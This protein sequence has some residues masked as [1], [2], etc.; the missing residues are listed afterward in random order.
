MNIAQKYIL[1]AYYCH[2]ST[3]FICLYEI[4]LY[5][6]ILDSEVQIHG[7]I[8]VRSDRVSR[9]GGGVCMF[10]SKTILSTKFV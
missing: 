6:G 10:L 1:L 7:F 9:P 8:N 4:F 3:K 5:E 2:S